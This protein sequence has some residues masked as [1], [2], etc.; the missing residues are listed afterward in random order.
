MRSAL[1]VGGAYVAEALFHYFV[2]GAS[3]STTALVRPFHARHPWDLVLLRAGSSALP[4]RR[5]CLH[6]ES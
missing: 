4:R 6:T 2:I 1:T 5:G 3:G